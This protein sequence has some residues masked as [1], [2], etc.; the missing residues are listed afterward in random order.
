MK[1]NKTIIVTILL[2][3]SIITIYYNTNQKNN[4]HEFMFK[5]EYE[6]LNNKD[7]GYGNK[8]L[9]ININKNN[10]IQYASFE[11]IKNI[12]TK[13][14]GIIYFGF[15]ECPWCR[16]IIEPLINANNEVEKRK[17]YYFN[18]YN[19]RDKKQLDEKNHII[20]EKEGTKEYNELIEIMY[21]HL[22]EYE[23]LNDKNIKRLYFPTV[24]FVKN[25]EIIYTH[26]GT[27][28]EQTN[29][30]IP[31]NNEQKEKLKNIYKKYMIKIKPTQC[32]DKC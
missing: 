31:L 32:D 11:E 13:G 12:L 9:N 6:E 18:A 28:D 22:G 14:T 20:I 7:N 3:I 26:I 2:I 10:N 8:H 16:N 30:Y 25:G 4:N 24:V 15:P 1:K 23:G 21:D 27:I 17:I 5:K 29:P 19:I